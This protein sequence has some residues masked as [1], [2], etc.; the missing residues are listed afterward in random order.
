MDDINQVVLRGRVLKDAELRTTTNHTAV[1]AFV[2][3]TSRIVNGKDVTDYT[4]IVAWQRLAEEMAD[5]RRGDPVHVVGRLQNRSW[6]DKEGVKHYKAEV[7]AASIEPLTLRTPA[8]V[9]LAEPR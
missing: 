8:V 2:V 5:L 4:N 7:V 1:L 9:A 3:T 6:Q